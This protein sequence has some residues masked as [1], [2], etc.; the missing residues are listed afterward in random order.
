MFTPRITIPAK[1]NRYYIAK[2]EGGLNPGVPRPKGSPLRFANCVF[3]ALGRFAELWG[4]WLKSTDAENFV[5]E[6]KKI[7]LTVSQTP[8]PGAVAV[9]A[10][11]AV[12]NSAD[13]AGHVAVVEIINASGSIVTSESGWNAKQEF[14]TTTRLP[15]G[16]WGQPAAYRFL[17][18]VLPPGQ[19]APAPSDAVPAVTLRKGDQGDGVRWMQRKLIA[20]GYL[21][22]NELDGDFGRITLGALLAFQLEHGLAV[23]GV[24]GPA[25]RAELAKV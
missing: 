9:W 24:C 20:A 18:F 11:G 7:G 4:I 8:V 25:T 10:K 1:D 21:R 14:W 12:G 19:A 13:G 6:A 15:G 23:D 3:Y 22:A 2:T 16:N 17:G 5:S